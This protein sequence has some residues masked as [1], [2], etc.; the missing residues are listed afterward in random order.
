MLYA[1]VATCIALGLAMAGCA[2]HAASRAPQ[3]VAYAGSLSDPKLG[4]AIYV[5]NCEVCHGANGHGDK[6]GPSLQN[7]RSRMDVTNTMAWIQSPAPPMPK[8]YPKFLTLQ[9]VRDVA[10]YVHS[11]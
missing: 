10:T 6:L 11:L 9:E 2:Q 4:A 7:E 3:S 8:L 1:K 5:A